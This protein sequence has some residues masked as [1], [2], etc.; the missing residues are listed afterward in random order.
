M[1][2]P[3]FFP[4]LVFFCLIPVALLA[5]TPPLHP[6]YYDKTCPNAELIVRDVMRKAMIREPRSGA[7]VMRL[8]FHDCFVNVSIFVS[9]F[10]ILWQLRYLYFNVWLFDPNVF[11]S[12][13]T[14]FVTYRKNIHQYINDTSIFF[15]SFLF[16]CC[17]YLGINEMIN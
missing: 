14:I 6:G 13:I 17:W 1:C 3:Y 7:S 10:S 4:H 2:L 15:F 9:L 5:A 11:L 16:N 12:L 8:Q